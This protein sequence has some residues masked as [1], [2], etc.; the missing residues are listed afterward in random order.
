MTTHQVIEAKAETHINKHLH[1]GDWAP[2]LKGHSHVAKQSCTYIDITQKT[3]TFKHPTQCPHNL[4]SGWTSQLTKSATFTY[5]H[6]EQKK[7]I[8]KVLEKMYT[9]FKRNVCPHNLQDA[10]GS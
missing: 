7:I 2:S 9:Y 3:P 1:Q 10:S 6:T 5:I 8:L 4:K